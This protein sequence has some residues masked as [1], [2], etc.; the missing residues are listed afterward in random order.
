MFLRTKKKMF[1]ENSWLIWDHFASQ[2]VK[3]SYLQKL[4]TESEFV[5][6]VFGYKKYPNTNLKMSLITV[7]SHCWAKIKTSQLYQHGEIQNYENGRIG[8]YD[9]QKTNKVIVPTVICSLLFFDFE[10][11]TSE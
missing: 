1:S 10:N 8:V 3:N 6:V 7:P 11:K 5:L 2:S 4:Q 9:I